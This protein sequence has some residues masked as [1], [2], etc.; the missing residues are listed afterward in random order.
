[1]TRTPSETPSYTPTITPTNTPSE[2]PTNTPTVTPS[3]TPTPTVTNTPT[4]TYYLGLYI[5]SGLGTIHAVDDAPVFDPMGQFMGWDIARDIEVTWDQ[6]GH[7]SGLYQLS[8]FGDVHQFGN[9]PI[10]P[11]SPIPYAGWDVFRD[12]EPAMDWTDERYG[13]AGFYLLD[14]FGGVHP[15]GETFRTDP[16]SGRQYFKQYRTARTLEFGEDRYDY[17]GWDIARDMEVA[18]GLR[19][20]DPQSQPYP[21]VRGYYILD[22]YG[23]VH[24]SLEGDSGNV[25]LAPWFPAGQPYFGWDIAKDIELS[26]TGLGYY[27][28]DGYGGIHI[29]GDARLP[30]AP[31]SLYYGWDIAKSL[32]IF[33]DKNGTTRAIVVLDGFGGIQDWG[34]LELGPSQFF[35]WDIARAAEGLPFHNYEF[36]DVHLSAF[37][38]E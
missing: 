6:N 37:P 4:P 20:D 3:N 7:A 36:C 38:T 24:W 25:E 21:I 27:L 5:L 10:Y 17:W 32:K 28:L 14:A 9:A 30:D 33:V 29:V 23:A 34:T 2:T 16:G 11:D 12:L 1:P 15:I 31:P 35:G 19:Q 18:V 13:Q 8:G 26:P 22:G